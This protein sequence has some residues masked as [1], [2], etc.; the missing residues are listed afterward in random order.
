MASNGG[1][2]KTANAGESWALVQYT[3]GHHFHDVEFKPGD[4]TIMY[5]CASTKFFR[6]TDTGDTWT[7]IVSGVPTNANRMAIGISPN[8]GSYV[9]L[10]AGPCYAT[11]TYVGTY[12][13]TNSGVSFSVR[14][15][16]PNILGYS[17][18]GNDD[19][20][21]SHYD[22]ALVV[23]LTDAE[24]IMTGGI[25]CWSSNNGGTSWLL[26]SMW[27]HPPGSTYTHADIH[28]LEI[29]PLNN[30]LY[31]GSDGGIF[32]ST[33]FGN[34]WTDLSAGLSITQIYRIAGY[35]P[36]VNFLTMGTQDNGS[37]KWTGGSDIFHMLGADGM[38]CMIDYSSGLTLYNSCQDGEL[39][40]CTTGGHMGGK[41]FNRP[42]RQGPGSHLLL[43]TRQ[44][45]LLFMAVIM[46]FTKVMMVDPIG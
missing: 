24:R 7:E 33:D 30:N 43:C 15:T 17:S 3:A 42:V 20:D 39:Y 38:D 29:N 34:N 26:K 36:D 11:S 27:N 23:S 41:T 13:S 21:Q 46:I 18:T 32:R 22:H 14:S 6:S 45:H 5:A 8:N 4:P 40:K 1:L 16:S 37:N 44:T 12:R 25:N 19:K 10:F 9:Y 28:A 35:Q 2:L 31:C